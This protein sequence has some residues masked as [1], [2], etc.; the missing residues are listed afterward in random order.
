MVSK[1]RLFP[2][3]VRKEIKTQWKKNRLYLQAFTKPRDAIEHIDAQT[4]HSYCN[5]SNN[6]FTVVDGKSVLLDQN[7]LDRL[8][9]VRS[10][11]ETAIDESISGV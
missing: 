4:T 2:E 3:D 7:S 9:S 1:G 6:V 11:I 10:G 8:R 5:L